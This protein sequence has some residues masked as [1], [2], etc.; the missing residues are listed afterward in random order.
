MYNEDTLA[1]R[2]AAEP[3]SSDERMKEMMGA[4]EGEFQNLFGDIGKYIV[5]KQ[6]S[7]LIGGRPLEPNDL[8][9]LIDTLS[10]SLTKVI[11]EDNA[12]DLKR[13]LRRKCGLPI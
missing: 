10:D 7:D 6:V 8:P 11:G 1:R 5:K 4:I 3:Q 13:R 2:G 12:K 9:R